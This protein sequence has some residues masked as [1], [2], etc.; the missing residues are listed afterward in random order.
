[1]KVYIKTVNGY[2]VYLEKLEEHIDIREALSEEE[3]GINYTNA[4][5]DVENGNLEY[6][7][8]HVIVAKVSNG[9]IFKGEDFLG[10]CIYEDTND[11]IKNS[12][13]F[14]DMIKAAIDDVMETPLIDVI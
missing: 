13:Y 11:F 10:C 2:E 3:T 6:F 8:A 14:D 1:M 4:I 5:D 9:T 7:C 12:G